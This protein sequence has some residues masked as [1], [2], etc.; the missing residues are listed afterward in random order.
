MAHFP[1]ESY[2]EQHTQHEDTAL[3]SLINNQDSSVF[4]TSHDLTKRLSTALSPPEQHYSTGERLATDRLSDLSGLHV[5]NELTEMC[6][7]SDFT[8]ML[9]NSDL[10]LTVN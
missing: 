1:K 2:R 4:L 5:N 10:R 7:D 8:D 3:E 9:S 6:L